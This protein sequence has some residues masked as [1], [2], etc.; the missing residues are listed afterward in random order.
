MFI[1]WSIKS[2][3]SSLCT[4]YKYLKKH[5]TDI[6]TTLTPLSHVIPHCPRS[7]PF[8]MLDVPQ[9][10]HRSCW[11]SSRSFLVMRRSSNEFYSTKR[12]RLKR[13]IPCLRTGLM[14]LPIPPSLKCKLQLSH[15]RSTPQYFNI[16]ITKL[17]QWQ[18]GIHLPSHTE[19]F[20]C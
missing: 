13:W 20:Q 7:F 5:I 12:D 14:M 9:S 16:T 4:V 1:V 17:E 19:M 2:V 6:I 8:W 15:L 11:F 3:W 10:E 18:R